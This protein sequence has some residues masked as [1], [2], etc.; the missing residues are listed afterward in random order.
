MADFKTILPAS[1][2]S[3]ALFLTS[4]CGL[5]T[6]PIHIFLCGDVM[7]GR[8]IDQILP[9]P[10][11]P[12]LHESHVRDARRYVQLAER[13]N[14]PIPRPVGLDYIWGDALAA[15]DRAG[16]DARVINLETSITRSDDFWHGKGINYRMHPANIGC[17]TAARID[18]CCLANN[19]VLD[20]GYDGLDE[21]LRTLD[22][23]GIAHAG[24]GR[25]ATLAAAP[26]VIDVPDKGRVLVFSFGAMTSGIPL[27]WRAG[28]DRPGVNLLT[29]ISA[30]TASRIAGEM[31]ASAR[32]G[33][34]I[35]AS[36][37]W[38]ENWGYRIAVE[39]ERFARRLIEE[40]VHIVH[41][42]S[43][44]HVKSIEIH[45]ERLVIYGCGDFL[46]DYEGIGGHEDFRGDLAMIY[47]ATI[48]PPTGRLLELRLLPMRMRRFRLRQASEADAL[49]L[50]GLLNRLG[51]PTGTRVDLEDGHSMTVR[52]KIHPIQAASP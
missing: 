11:D 8:G 28:H 52:A 33:D 35:V 10:C 48:D 14:G 18:C 38:G 39:E 26:A 41:G 24:A 13:I 25:N 42:H 2:K 44:H 36:I 31:A 49:W 37:H 1:G 7:T 19:H 12:E 43:S 40:G 3:Q 17:L 47:L 9:C 45:D 23:A 51:T 32:P 29:D 6:A 46:N 50:A 15:L 30:G 34:G 16:T 20:W 5:S 4:M 22:D 27:E 21:T